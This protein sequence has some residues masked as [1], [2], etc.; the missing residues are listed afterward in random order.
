MALIITKPLVDYK[1]ETIDNIN[2]LTQDT[3]YAKY[4]QH[5]QANLQAQWSNLVFLDAQLGAGIFTNQI[6]P[7]GL[8][9]QAAWNW[10][11]S[12][13]DIN[14]I[15]TNNIQLAISVPDILTI[16]KDYKIKLASM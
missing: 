2:K 4:P 13:R 9:I 1:K 16:V 15:A 14:H 7:E 10:I 3:I 5:T 6:S 11:K 8:I 12:V